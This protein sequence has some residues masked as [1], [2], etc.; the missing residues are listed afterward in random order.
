[1][2]SDFSAIGFTLE[3]EE[4][5]IEFTRTETARHPKSTTPVGGA[6]VRA[7]SDDGS[8][9]WIQVDPDGNAIGAH[10]HFDGASRFRVRIVRAR[11]PAGGTLLDGLMDCT[12]LEEQ[13]GVPLAVDVPDYAMHAAWATEGADAVLQIAAFPRQASV[14]ATDAEF[15]ASRLG[16]LSAEGAFI[17]SGMFVS[18]AR[19]H[20]PPTSDAVF[21]GRVLDAARRVNG[22]TGVSYWSVVVK[23]LG[24]TIDAVF[25]Q[26]ECADAPAAGSIVAGAFVL[27]ARLREPLFAAPGS[28]LRNPRAAQNAAIRAYVRADAPKRSFLSRVFGR[29]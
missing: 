12:M 5:F 28:S 4:Q 15:D 8:A 13:E 3:S 23:T 22:I 29:K 7:G 19:P 17:P 25:D 26:S 20:G 6:Y 18:E 24:G 1:M 27:S 11:R 10:P 21:A 14:Y 2:P 9:I 16:K